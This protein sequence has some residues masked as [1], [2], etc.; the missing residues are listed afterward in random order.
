MFRSMHSNIFCR[1]SKYLGFFVLE[2]PYLLVKKPNY[3][4]NLQRWLRNKSRVRLI[5]EIFIQFC[6]IC[7]TKPSP[8]L[9]LSWHLSTHKQLSTNCTNMLGVLNMSLT[10][11][12]IIQ[13]YYLKI[14]FKKYK[15][16]KKIRCIFLKCWMS[17]ICIQLRFC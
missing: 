12:F 2:L 15:R 4:L 3:G 6:E 11:I 8:S 16:K 9:F 10:L 1:T 5:E 7:F 17:S 13:L 14:Y